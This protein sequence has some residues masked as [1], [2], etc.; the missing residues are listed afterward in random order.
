MRSLILIVVSALF[1]LT[2]QLGYGQNNFGLDKEL[3]WSNF[4]ESLDVYH[5]QNP[6]EKA[7]LHLD[8]EV[9]SPNEEIWFS[10]YL[11]L[12]ADHLYSE[13]SKVLHVDLISQSKDIVASQTVQLSKGRAQGSIHFPKDLE[14]GTYQIRSYTN[15]MRNFDQ[16]FFYKKQVK[17]LGRVDPS[18][19]PFII[20]A[21]LDLQFFPEG[22]NLIDGLTTKIAFRAVGKDGMGKVISGYVEDS[23]GNVVAELNTVSRGS[24]IF[25]LLPKANTNYRAVLK[26]GTVYPLPAVLSEGYALS[27]G[28]KEYGKIVIQVQ[29]SPQ[30]ANRSFYL[31]GLSRGKRY[32]QE[33]LDLGPNDNQT[34][35]IS[36]SKIPSGILS[37]SLFDDQGNPH[38]ERLSFINNRE[39]LR[40]SATTKSTVF[41]ARGEIEV[42]IVVKDSNGMPVSSALSVSISDADQF[43]KDTGSSNIRSY[44]LLQSDLRGQIH[45]PAELF[46]DQSRTT[47]YQLDLVMLTHGWRKYQWPE[48]LNGQSK[49]RAFSFAQGTNIAGIAYGRN[50]QLLRN[51]PFKIIAKS[52]TNLSEHSFVTDDFGRFLV[53]NFNSSGKAELVFN[54]YNSKGK[55]QCSKVK[56]QKQN[57][58]LPEPKFDFIPSEH[59]DGEENYQ[60]LSAIRSQG[61]SISSIEGIINLDEVSVS[62]EK[63]EKKEWTRPSKYGIEPDRVVYADDYPNSV[64]VMHLIGRMRGMNL[65]NR[66]SDPR[67]GPLWVVDGFPM[68]RFG[69]KDSIVGGNI[70]EL[71]SG[72]PRAIAHIN[73]QSIERIEYLDPQMASNVIYGV[74]GAAGVFLIYTKIGSNLNKKPKSSNLE[75]TVHSTGK[76]FYSPLYDS[77]PGLEDVS[78]FRSTLFWDPMLR[79]DDNGKATLRFFNSDIANKIQINIEGLSTTGLSGTFLKTI[80][81]RNFE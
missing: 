20:D 75:L 34:L 69:F 30:Y 63:T 36:T 77:E 55:I 27:V 33:R 66:I 7:Y 28:S 58:Q 4:N 19:N 2:A 14:P 52:E 38:C 31:L 12:G 32:F 47:Q 17:V 13:A 72:V 22:G 15:W 48:I 65:P 62:T 56:L 60:R 26:D 80:G 16:N 81:A 49:N 10:A 35:E 45:R 59:S 11:V 29:A 76:E 64:D 40:I 42:D 61:N 3:V 46:R 73:V 9:V 18:E 78:D 44:L 53:K 67:G 8:K 79:T 71:V 6:I 5:S 50:D 41:H 23:H 57:I 24:G 51:T 68:P 54:A 37:L 43:A 25:Y 39:N 74:Q 21:P 1:V 70:P